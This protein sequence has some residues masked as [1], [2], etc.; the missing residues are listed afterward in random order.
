MLVARGL[1]TDSEAREA[2]NRVAASALDEL[3]RRRAA[4]KAKKRRR[5]LD[6]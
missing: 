5:R 6:E 4:K 3:R 1:A 2:M